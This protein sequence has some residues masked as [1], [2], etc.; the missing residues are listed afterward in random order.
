[1]V[2]YYSV[3]LYRFDETGKLYLSETRDVTHKQLFKT[4]K[5][6]NEK[7]LVRYTE[8]KNYEDYLYNVACAHCPHSKKCHDDGESCEEFEEELKKHTKERTMIWTN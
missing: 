2:K 8:F 7:G 1:M 3:C 5:E 6:F 4:I